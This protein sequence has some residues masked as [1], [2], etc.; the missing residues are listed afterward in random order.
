MSGSVSILV[1]CE[2]L[3]AQVFIE[4]ALETIDP[5]LLHRLRVLPY[6]QGGSCGSQFVRD[7]YPTVVKE[8]RIGQRLNR[9]SGC[10]AIV[11]V[12]V[13]NSTPEGRTVEDRRRELVKAC[14]TRA[15]DPPNLEE[16]VAHLIP[17]RNIETWIRF[18]L[19]GEP[20]K[21]HIDYGHLPRESK[22]QPAAARF[23]NHARAA[24]EPVNAPP[25]LLTALPEFRKV[26]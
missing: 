20:V 24:T 6:P 4:D 16:P 3:Q 18:L 22:A 13:D 25:S 19:T 1:L 21:E 7:Y 14:R 10:R 11:H 12:D 15:V 23:A 26:L 5:A 8:R 2:D 9:T 17:R